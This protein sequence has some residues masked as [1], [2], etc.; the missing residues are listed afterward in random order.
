MNYT[1]ND[2]FMIR[3]PSLPVNVFT[4]FQTCAYSAYGDPEL[5][6]HL[7]RNVRQLISA[8]RKS[9]AHEVNLVDIRSKTNRVE[10]YLEDLSLLTGSTGVAITLLSLKGKI[11]TGK[12]LM[13][14]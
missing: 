14:D 1:C 3:T 6:S 8:Y 9:N 11:A 13:I 10:G 7:E 2:I 4:D 12:L 5:L